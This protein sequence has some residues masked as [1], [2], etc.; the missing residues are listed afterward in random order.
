MDAVLAVTADYANV[1]SDGKF[2]IMGIFQ[3]ITPMAFPAQVSQM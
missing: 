3:E 2:S 1:S